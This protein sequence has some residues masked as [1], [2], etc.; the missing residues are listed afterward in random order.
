MSTEVIASRRATNA[1]ASLLMLACV[2]STSCSVEAP[3]P[4]ADLRFVDLDG[5]E[6]ALAEYRGHGV[7]LNF[8]AIWCSPCVAE[9][10]ELLET[11]DKFRDEGG[12]V[13]TISYDLMIPG[14][15]REA[16]LPRLEAF[17]FE[18]EMD[19]PVLVFD[20]NDYDGINARFDLPGEIPVTLAINRQGKAVDRQFGRA[21]KERFEQMMRRA[22]D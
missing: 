10:P 4:A 14:E 6:T 3:A 22:L 20:E 9:L 8:W 2:L 21:D 1:I 13:V 19:V 5:I 7:L 17:M 15:T 18:R 12:V 16:L 11:G